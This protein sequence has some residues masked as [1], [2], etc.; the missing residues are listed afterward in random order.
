MFFAHQAIDWDAS[1]LVN[2]VIECLEKA[3]YQSSGKI[4]SLVL[5]LSPNL[6]YSKWSN[7]KTN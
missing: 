7:V 6:G 4:D 2:L 5:I 1:V 3:R